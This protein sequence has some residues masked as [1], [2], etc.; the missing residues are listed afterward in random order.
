MAGIFNIDVGGIVSGITSMVDDLHTSKEEEM[1]IGLQ[2]KAMDVQIATGQ[3]DINKTEARHKSVFV[4]GWRPWIGWV[5]GMALAYQFILYHFL[6]W[7]W[8]IMQAKGWI[9]AEL[10][11]PPVLEIN[12]LMAVVF[13]MLGVGGMRSFDKAKG[14][15]TDAINAPPKPEKKKKWMGMF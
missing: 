11:A 14:T 4:A 15:A 5:C 10:S 8:T 13:A 7:T 9:P 12:E 6:V 2:D 3:M 1:L